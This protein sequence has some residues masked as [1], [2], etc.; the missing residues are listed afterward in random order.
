[1]LSDPIV[2][3]ATPPGRS[4]IAV[5]RVSGTG[6][7]DVVGRCLRPFHADRPRAAL[8]ARLV[9][10]ATHEQVDDVIAA[11]FPA[12]RSYTGE[13]VVEISTH[14]GLLIPGEAVADLVAAGARPAQPGE[15]TRRALLNG[16]LDLLQAEATADLI[17]AGAPA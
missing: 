7:F 10:P 8:R 9:H 2:A 3:L 16:K 11:A 5:I 6:A 1:V 17:D 15:F 4:A 14:G 12:P 13:D